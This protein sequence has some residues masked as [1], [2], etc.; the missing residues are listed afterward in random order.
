MQAHDSIR[1]WLIVDLRQGKAVTILDGAIRERD[2]DDLALCDGL[3]THDD[4]VEYDGFLP[5]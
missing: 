5:T 2:T 4:L 1:H 3:D